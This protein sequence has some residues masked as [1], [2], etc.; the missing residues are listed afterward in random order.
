MS[1][2]KVETTQESLPLEPRPVEMVIK[3]V[4]QSGFTV[5]FPLMADKV[6][7]YGFLKMAEKTIDKHY[8]VIE[9]K[10]I[11]PIKQGVIDFARRRF[12]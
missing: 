12:K 10:R 5:S 6:A 3:L 8:K 9:E 1:D 11:T 7:T 2:D 4:P